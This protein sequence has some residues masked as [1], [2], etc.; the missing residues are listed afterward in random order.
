MSNGRPPPRQRKGKLRLRSTPRAFWRVPRAAPS[1]FAVRTSQSRTPGGG[2]SPPQPR[3]H[4]VAGGLRAVDR[5]DDQHADGRRRVAERASRVIGRALH[6]PAHR[7]RRGSP[8]GRGPRRRRAATAAVER[9]ASSTAAR[10]RAIAPASLAHDLACPPTRGHGSSRGAG[11]PRKTAGPRS[12]RPRRWRARSS[13]ARAASA[14][15]SPG[16]SRATAT[17]SRSSTSSSP[18]TRAR[19]L[20]R[21]VAPDPRRATARTP[22]Y[23]ASARRAARAV[24]RAGGR[25]RRGPATWSAG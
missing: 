24:A 7:L 23:T 6:R 11:R 8:R 5:A 17:R 19:Q 21:R 10:A 14:P 20:G 9:S 2:S 12:G 18:A 15:R 25:V 22:S 1:G 4:R 16:S 3:D 13:S